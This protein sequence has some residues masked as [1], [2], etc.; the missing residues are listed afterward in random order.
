MP[1]RGGTSEPVR[2]GDGS[3]AGPAVEF[4]GFRLAHRTPEREVLLLEDVDLEVPPGFHLVVGPSGSG[5]SSLMRLI[6]GLLDRREVPPSTKGQLRIFGQR[7]V[8]GGFPKTLRPRVAAILQD[9]GLI[10]DLTPR[11]NVE[12]ALRAAGRSRKLAPALLAQVG[13]DPIPERIADLSGGMRK[14][15]AIARALAG[16]PDLL[17]CDEPTAGLDARSAREMA[18]LLRR[19]HDQSQPGSTNGCKTTLVISHDVAAFEEIVDRV[20]WF[21]PPNHSLRCLEPE[22]FRAVR[23]N[24][25][26][27]TMQ[28]TA[29]GSSQLEFAGAPLH[30]VRKWLLQFAAI[31]DTVVHSIVRL[32]PVEGRRTL[33]TIVRF[34]LQPMLFVV[35]CSSMIGGLATFFALRNNPL[36]GAFTAQVMTG[37]GKVLIAVLVPLLSGFFFTARMAAGAAARL[38]T[39]KRTQQ[40]SGL[41][42]MGIRPVDYLLTPLTWGM[43]VAMPVTAFAS[44]VGASFASLLATKLVSTT[45][46]Y[47]WSIAFFKTVDG[48]DVIFALAKTSLSGYL[49]ALSTWY[50]ATGP[51]RSGREVGEAVNASI[52]LGIALVLT[53]HAVATIFQ[54]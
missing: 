52:V 8:R 49:V 50:L 9:E 40:L 39:M 33:V 36:Q 20:L 7:V 16:E 18:N 3:M 14:R 54:F 6:V 32:P 4:I 46:T 13:L 29:N 19:G 2:D 30:G 45:S 38:G 27:T 15:L 21:D 43:V 35:L 24:V 5:K 41:S 44:I 23:A 37:A 26:A 17:V 51:K 34:V 47:G 25:G 53:V 31:G 42:M 12:L 1:T 28:P 10:D 11:G 48:R 22:M